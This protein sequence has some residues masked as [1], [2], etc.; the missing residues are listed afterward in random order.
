MKRIIPA[1]IIAFTLANLSSCNEKP[2]SDQ[3]VMR[4]KD[5]T[6]KVEKIAAKNDTDA[7]NMYLDR[8][9]AVIVASIEKKEPPFEA[10]FVISPEGD[11]LNTNKELLEYV[12][13][14][15]QSSQPDTIMLGTIPAKK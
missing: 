2:K 9:S 13:R 12:S 11:T 8:M 15:F 5:G 7:L 10:M 4:A 3:F 1:L 6:E 14:S